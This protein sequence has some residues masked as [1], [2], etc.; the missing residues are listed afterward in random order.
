M[1]S[2]VGAGLLGAG[3]KARPAQL[4]LHQR[5]GL[6]EESPDATNGDDNEKLQFMTVAQVQVSACPADWIDRVFYTDELARA[7]VLLAHQLVVVTSK[8][9][10]TSGQMSVWCGN[11][12]ASHLL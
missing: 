7:C 11:A 2:N 1:L 12:C 9:L 10:S 5:H 8:F 3:S 4:L 6:D